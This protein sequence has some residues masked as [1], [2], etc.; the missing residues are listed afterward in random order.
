[1]PIAALLKFLPVWTNG[2]FPDYPFLDRMTVAFFA[3]VFLMVAISLL[4]PESEQDHET[5]IIEVDK[6]M[7]KVSSEFVIGSFI[8]SGILVALYTVF[9]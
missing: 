4:N 2:F 7:F 9:W 5:H 8:I 3:I 6:S 1:V